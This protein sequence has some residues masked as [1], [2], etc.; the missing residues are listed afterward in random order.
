MVLRDQPDG[1]AVTAEL[2]RRYPEAE[3]LVAAQIGGKVAKGEMAWG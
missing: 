3:L 1:A 2:V